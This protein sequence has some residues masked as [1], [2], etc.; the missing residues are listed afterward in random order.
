MAVQNRGD[1]KSYKAN[2]DLRL[3][4]FH[5]IGLP[6]SEKVTY[7]TAATQDV[8]GVLLNAPNTNDVAEVLLMN[9][10]GTVKAIAGS[11]GVA[12]G[13]HVGSDSTG[14]CVAL[15]QAGAGVQPT[16]RQV[17]IA[18]SAAAD[19]EAFELLILPQLY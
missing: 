3:L 5:L 7:T 1:I 16:Q 11:G 2:A 13:N 10:H 19:G 18:L 8:L 6:S 9:A 15:T 14:K 4:Q 17:G 12:V